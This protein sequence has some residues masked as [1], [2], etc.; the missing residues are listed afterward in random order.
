MVIYLVGIFGGGWN[1]AGV[2]NGD[3]VGEGWHLRGVW[4]RVARFGGM[5]AYWYGLNGID[6]LWGF[7][8]M[9][10]P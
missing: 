10:A 4:W 8:A 1:A 7:L 3:A 6:G 9:Y 2:E 5:V